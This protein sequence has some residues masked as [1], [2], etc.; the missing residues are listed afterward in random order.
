LTQLKKPFL[1]FIHTADLHLGSTFQA[2]YDENT[3]KKLSGATYQAFKKIIDLC[4]EEN[5]EF[6]LVSGDI[7][8]SQD[9][10]IKAQ[11]AF[12]QGLKRLGEYGI[13]S[14]VVHGNH[15]P[16]SFWS[17][18]IQLPEQTIRFSCKVP[19]EYIHYSSEGEPLAKIVGMSFENDHILENIATDF[20]E[21]EKD[22]PFTIGLLHCTIGSAI[23]HDPFAPC[24]LDD[25]KKCGYDYWAL[26][27]IHKPG[28]I[29]E[30][31]PVIVYSGNPQGRDMGE[32]GPRGCYLVTID[33]SGSISKKFLDTSTIRWE[34]VQ[35]ATD[36]IATFGDLDETI[37]KNL[38]DISYKEK[39]DLICRVELIGYCQIYDEIIDED[40]LLDFT[41]SLN[42]EQ[43]SPNYM[44]I[45]DKIINKT[46]PL[47]DREQVKQRNDIV[48]DICK[49]VD[50]LT[51]SSTNREIIKKTID[52]LFRNSRFRYQLEYPDDEEMFSLIS[53]AEALL[54]SK[55]V[56]GES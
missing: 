55:M 43:I 30:S 8:D 37:R 19:E 51:D 16:M 15:D 32:T 10:N 5:V 52:E 56:G 24:N 38:L 17:K 25:L 28:V 14:Y 3:A 21:R 48:S 54:F 41:Q 26:G 45:V 50:E 53:R 42:A 9:K 22:W 49:I 47:I 31:Q 20:P 12:I 35:I 1:K 27:H 11:L 46:L 44:V 7:Y 23:G 4:I 2:K 36:G 18:K 6:L 29:N 33:Q 13:K 39:K 40:D 34:N